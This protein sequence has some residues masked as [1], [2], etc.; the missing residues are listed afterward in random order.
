[1]ARKRRRI[2]LPSVEKR[3]SPD[4]TMNYSEEEC[5]TATCPEKGCNVTIIINGGEAAEVREFMELHKHSKHWNIGRLPNEILIKIFSY[6]VPNCKNCFQQRE[7]LKLASVCRRFNDLIRAPDLYRELKLGYCMWDNHPP[8]PVSVLQKIIKSSG[9][10]LRTVMIKIPDKDLFHTNGHFIALIKEFS[11]KMT[12]FNE[13]HLPALSLIEMS[14]FNFSKVACKVA[15]TLV[16]EKGNG[17]LFSRIQDLRVDSE[18]QIENCMAKFAS[19]AIDGF[20]SLRQVTLRCFKEKGQKILLATFD[21]YLPDL[22][23]S[24]VRK[25]DDYWEID[26]QQRNVGQLPFVD[27]EVVLKNF[28][29]PFSCLQP[30]AHASSHNLGH[31]FG[32]IKGQIY[33]FQ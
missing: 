21:E 25:V 2:S 23:Y 10:Q 33:T 31:F 16:L 15:I 17:P 32:Q 19:L 30:P 8:P 5:G 20:K 6:V 11:K 12:L 3:I 28:L 29:D 1:M 22:L 27:P 24:D 18:Y 13:H 26:I 9:S 7:I 4:Q 14:S